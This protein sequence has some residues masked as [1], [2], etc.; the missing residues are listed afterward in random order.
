MHTLLTTA[1]STASDAPCKVK[2]CNHPSLSI[3][4]CR[5][6]TCKHVVSVD[7]YPL[8]LS[9]CS[10]R[11]TLLGGPNGPGGRRG[12]TAP[13]YPAFFCKKCWCKLLAK[14]TPATWSELKFCSYFS[15]VNKHPNTSI[16][17]F[18]QGPHKFLPSCYACTDLDSTSG[19][20][21]LPELHSCT[22]RVKLPSQTTAC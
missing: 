9:I 17:A 10:T 1:P 20:Q 2:Q 4:G 14:R 12:S 7:R 5:T 19:E 11:P 3:E 13:L 8:E 15:S 21:K 6:R 18:Q 22:R 16:P